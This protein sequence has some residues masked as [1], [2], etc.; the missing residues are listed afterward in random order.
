MRTKF[1]FLGWNYY[2]YKIDSAEKLNIEKRNCERRE[3][4][5]VKNVSNF[6]LNMS[7]WKKTYSHYSPFFLR[8][9]ANPIKENYVLKKTELALN[10]KTAHESETTLLLWSKLESIN[11]RLIWLKKRISLI[12][13]TPKS[14][15][16]WYW[17]KNHEAQFF[18]RFACEKVTS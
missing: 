10:C 1:A 7:N 9:R 11:L 18:N 8:K 6:V 2:I 12:G 17:G 14:N 16:V 13:L 5:S 15:I 4:A 3:N